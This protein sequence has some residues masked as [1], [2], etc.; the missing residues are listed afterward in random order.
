MAQPDN[1]GDPNGKPASPRNPTQ[2]LVLAL[3]GVAVLL[4]LFSS[5]GTE[6]SISYSQLLEQIE[7]KNIARVKILNRQIVGEFK[8]PVAIPRPEL[9]A[10]KQPAPITR[11]QS[12]LPPQAGE[13]WLLSGPAR[14]R[15]PSRPWC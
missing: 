8:Q 3:M 7:A 5:W 2:W 11:F 13:D 9:S 6:T 4:V 1:N 10:D 12:T 14:T 15:T